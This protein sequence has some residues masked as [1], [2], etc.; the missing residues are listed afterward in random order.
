MITIQNIKKSYKKNV[1]LDDVNMTLENKVYGLLGPNGSG[2]TTLLRI[3]SGLLKADHG[4]IVF[5]DKSIQEASIG[6]LPQKF[7]VF[8]ELSVYE[9]LEYYCI[10]KKIP[11]LQ[12][13]ESIQEV[14][15]SVNLEDMINRHCKE[16]SGGMVR[17]LGIA[18]T[19]LGNPDI[20][21]LD[22]PSAGLDVEERLRFKRILSAKDFPF[23][24]VISTHIVED[25]ESTCDILIVLK[26]GRIIYTGTPEDILKMLFDDVDILESQDLAFECDCSK[27][28]MSGALM[29]VGKD[30]I[31]AMIDEDHGCEMRCHFCNTAYQ[32]SEDELKELLKQMK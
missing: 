21:L 31:Q 18:Q 26:K 28:K 15:E 24:I 30:E 9:Q 8:K 7:G 10:L 16:L 11:Q 12:R 19:F 3:I 6:Y 13:K 27:D 32:F 20:I 4:S 5:Q 14:L 23:P 25:V 29:T 2:K 17:R 1:A 22:E